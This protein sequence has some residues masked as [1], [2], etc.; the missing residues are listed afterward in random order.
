MND[1]LV[2]FLLV[3]N[4]STFIISHCRLANTRYT[5]QTLKECIARQ[6]LNNMP[7]RKRN[8]GKDRKVRKAQQ[9][10]EKA[11]L[12]RARVHGVWTG[13]ARGVDIRSGRKVS[14]CKHGLDL[15][16]PN[17]T[18]HPVVKF[19]DAL[20]MNFANKKK[21]F[22]DIF[23]PHLRDAW[24]NNINKKMTINIMMSIG[25][26]LLLSEDEKGA[27]DLI[28][29]LVTLEGYVGRG[30]ISQ[31]SRTSARKIR[32]IG[33]GGQNS[34]KRDTKKFYRKRIACKC[35][36]EMHL[37]ARKSPPKLGVCYHCKEVKERALLMVCGRCRIS[38]YCSRECQIA[39]WPRHK[40]DCGA[41]IDMFSE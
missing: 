16:I 12:E 4:K 18:D 7:S 37:E 23:Q 36:K 28:P 31:Y 19:L 38:Q 20:Y 17:D 2:I 15:T 14:Q 1:D 8:K 6:R 32:Y 9:E 22:K 39:S 33:S 27:H 26:N 13:W 24:E 21:G 40:C 30:D 11:E 35:L 41:L 5:L 29:T 25:T 10:A 34:M 3:F